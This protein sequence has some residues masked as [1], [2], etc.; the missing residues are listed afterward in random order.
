[1]K[2][3]EPASTTA[4]AMTSLSP[5]GQ[6]RLEKLQGLKVRLENGEHIQNKTLQIWLLKEEFEQIAGR[7]E[8]KKDK[9]GFFAS[10]PSA[11]TEYDKKMQ[12]ATFA[13]NQGENYSHLHNSKLAKKFHNMSQSMFESALEYIRNEAE[14]DRSLYA[15]FDRS[16]A[17]AEYSTIGLDPSSMPRVVT[18]RSSENQAA[19]RNISKAQIK[20]GV[21]NDAIDE[22]TNDIRAIGREENKK[23]EEEQEKIGKEKSRTR[24]SVMLEDLKRNRAV[25]KI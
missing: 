5:E 14:T 6:K 1:M 7:F 4:P 19:N 22:I 25:G 21:I 23:N 20:M 8:M 24:L 18:S 10:K 12:K 9:N 16:F 15:W 17:N 2:T 11:V 3:T 13:H